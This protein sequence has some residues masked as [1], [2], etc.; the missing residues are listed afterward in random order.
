MFLDFECVGYGCPKGTVSRTRLRHSARQCL[1]AWSK[2]YGQEAA[3]SRHE[4]CVLHHNRQPAASSLESVTMPTV[5]N[6]MRKWTSLQ[7]CR[8]SMI[9]A[10]TSRCLQGALLFV[11]LESPKVAGFDQHLPVGLELGIEIQEYA[12]DVRC[13]RAFTPSF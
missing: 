9:F 11:S 13:L 1:A 5:K 10:L 6:M 7:S 3:K 2:Q 8:V 12:A 4:Q